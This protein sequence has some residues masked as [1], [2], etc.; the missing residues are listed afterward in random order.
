VNQKWSVECIDQTLSLPTERRQGSNRGATYSP[1]P[2]L[3]GL[4]R[5]TVRKLVSA[6]AYRLMHP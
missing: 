2:R 6:L 5:E 1:S 3:W 4:G